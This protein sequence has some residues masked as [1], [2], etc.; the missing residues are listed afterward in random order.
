[1]KEIE[2]SC[3]KRVGGKES[4]GKTYMV[5]SKKAFSGVQNFITAFNTVILGQPTYAYPMA[6]Y[7]N[8]KF[9]GY[10]HQSG[11]KK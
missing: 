5:G 7:R 4:N 10:Q 9:T 1:M 11:T 6:T 8:N 2:T 3:I